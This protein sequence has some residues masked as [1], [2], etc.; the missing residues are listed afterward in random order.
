MPV[1]RSE[2]APVHEVHNARF[3]SLIRPDVGSCELC[4]WR[5]EVA[6]GSQGVPHRILG[7][8]AFVLLSGAVGMLIDGESALLAPGDAAIAPAGS[9]IALSNAGAEPAVLLVTVRRGFAAELPD[10]STFVPPWAS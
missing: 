6:P 8:E 4:V 1:V 5:T 2:H 3:I 9:V 7:E 10:G